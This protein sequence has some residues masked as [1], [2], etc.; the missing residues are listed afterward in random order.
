MTNSLIV[1]KIQSEF[2]QADRP[3]IKTGMEIEI[4]QKIKE[5]QKERIQRF[6]GVEVPDD[7]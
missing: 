5:G 6:K 2:V 7:E 4:Y 3:E 1:Q